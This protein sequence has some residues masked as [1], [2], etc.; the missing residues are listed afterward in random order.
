[1]GHRKR[2][3]QQRQRRFNLQCEARLRDPKKWLF[4]RRRPERLLESYQERYRV[5]PGQAYLELLELGLQDELR[6]RAYEEEGIPWEF[7]VE[8]LTGEMFVVPE[9]TPDDEIYF[10]G[11]PYQ[12]DD[13]EPRSRGH[14]QTRRRPR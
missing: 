10:M 1:M 12:R 9:G 8:P 4:T 7:R 3:R 2:K 13:D 11:A 5:G 14:V 6:I